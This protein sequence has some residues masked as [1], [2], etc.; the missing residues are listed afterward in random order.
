MED[1]VPE[2][3]AEGW[4]IYSSILSG[5][6]KPMSLEDWNALPDD[7]SDQLMII[8]EIVPMVAEAKRTTTV[9]R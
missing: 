3:V 6:C 8:I 2:E 9:E 7:V 5:V 4:E 1:S